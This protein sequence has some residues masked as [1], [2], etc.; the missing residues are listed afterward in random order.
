[1]GLRMDTRRSLILLDSS[2]SMLDSTIVGIVQRRHRSVAAKRQASKWRRALAAADWIIEHL[3]IGSQFQL[4]T[5]DQEARPVIA[6]T[7]GQWLDASSRSAI[8]NARDGLR[9]IVPEGGTSLHAAVRAMA[10][11]RPRP[12]SVY[13]ILDGLPTVG[14]RP[15]GRTTISGLERVELLQDAMRELPHGIAVTVILYPLEGDPG[16]ASLYWD[17]AIATG[18]AFLSPADDWPEGG[19]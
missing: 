10:T 12:E 19:T 13:L 14:T 3:P 11:M 2:A 7:H 15:S 16:A 6:G 4:Y 8:Q 9:Q 18:G 1:M 17:L 5:F